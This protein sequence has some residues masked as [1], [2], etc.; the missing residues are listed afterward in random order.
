MSDLLILKASAGSGKTFT[1]AR[2]YLKLVLIDI[3]YFRQI[4]AVTFTNKATAELKGRILSELFQIASAQ[5][6]DH[7]VYLQEQL[8][9]SQEGLKKRC[10]ETLSALLQDYSNFHIYTI[11]GFFQYVLKG[12][13][14]EIGIH[15]QYNIEMNQDQILEKATD[16]VFYELSENNDDQLVRWLTKYSET[17]IEDGNT[18]NLK[19]KIK[20]L[21]REL[22]SEQYKFHVQ[23]NE[24]LDEVLHEISELQNYIVGFNSA[25]GK[26]VAFMAGQI[27]EE[28]KKNGIAKDDFKGKS[29]SV[30][31]A[32]EKMF[33][34]KDY[35][36]YTGQLT[37]YIDNEEEVVPKTGTRRAELQSFYSCFLN[38]SIKMLSGIFEEEYSLVVRNRLVNKNLYSLG[39]IKYV[40]AAM[41]KLN[42]EQN[43]I[44]ISDS[45]EL[46][47]E[48][49]RNTDAPFIYEKSGNKF[50]HYMIDEFQDTSRLQ[51]GNLYPLV[52]NSLAYGKQNLIVGDVKQSIYR[53]RNSDW[54]ML[55][56]GILDQFKGRNVSEQ[57]LPANYRSKKTIIDFN[58]AFF[59]AAKEILA[60]D[61]KNNEVDESKLV[62]LAYE[63]C[64]QEYGKKSE[65]GFVYGEYLEAENIEDY[66]QKA[67]ETLMVQIKEILAS[68]YTQADL[69]ILVRKNSDGKAIIE[70]YQKQFKNGDIR[71]V[72]E[73][74]FYLSSSYVVQ[75]LISLLSYLKTRSSIQLNEVL[76]IYRNYFQNISDNSLSDHKILNLISQ[77]QQIAGLKSLLNLVHDVI[78][79]FKLDKQEGQ[80]AFLLALLDEMKNLHERGASGLE[81]F[82]KFWDVQGERL[83]LKDAQKVNAIR[84]LTVHKSKGLEFNVVLLP[85]VH[86]DLQ[87]S[88]ANAPILWCE[89]NFF[90]TKNLA[91]LPVKF[92]SD[93]AKTPYREA[94]FKEKAQSIIDSL[95]LLY[96][97]F[98]RAREGLCFITYKASKS[99]ALRFTSDLMHAVFANGDFSASDQPL[100]NL[101]QC[102]DDEQRTFR[103]GEIKP[104]GKEWE[105]LGDSTYQ[106]QIQSPGNKIK[107]RKK[108]KT[109]VSPMAQ[110]GD[111]LNKLPA[112]SSVRLGVLL[113]SFFENIDSLK[114]WDVQIDR[115][116][117]EN[118]ISDE[119]FQEIKS[120]LT[121]SVSNK[122]VNTWFADDSEVLNEVS[123][124]TPEGDV[125]RPDRII[126]RNN[127]I[128]VVDYKFG[129]FKSNTH[130]TQ[131][132][133]YVLALQ[134]MYD[135][136]IKAH[137]WYVLLDDVVSV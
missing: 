96:V 123:L 90:E 32:I 7:A 75:F 59:H 61:W 81:D 17:E 104:A 41:R 35:Y 46:I 82:L 113:H 117:R 124:L 23:K 10:I 111:K 131:V 109:A 29:R 102:N 49:T 21:G 129:R 30:L 20:S 98:T 25:F 69:A 93:L 9:L 77:F 36:D 116:Q 57:N 54:K 67:L 115:L 85:F 3:Y 12:F 62:E 87:H 100:E 101:S 66:R 22:F 107:I 2:L 42:N 8:C 126:K 125:L 88:P 112:I 94:Y 95:N 26:K 79:Q 86:W 31:S 43:S 97:A 6:S 18:W 134:Q 44:L 83:V 118:N 80:E 72:S 119:Q 73:E 68:G 13:F 40:H 1:I 130:I 71:F 52:E 4:L 63:N 38:D 108:A 58:N 55:G 51:W 103:M 53:W 56:G 45:N 47:A 39:V 127:E 70:Y 122:H 133:R 50:R 27:L 19:S 120:R 105:E 106:I 132:K 92:V 84:I 128:L 135:C 5:E 64:Y 15:N 24:K 14:K 99:S 16:L 11:D 114:Q 37:K 121:K 65:G 137:V 76:F 48:I 33:K 34:E 136:L 91:V 89:N 74:S 60:N 110:K 78:L 28:A